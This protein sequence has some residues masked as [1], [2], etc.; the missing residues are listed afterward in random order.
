M[1]K[2]AL[3]FAWIVMIALVVCIPFGAAYAD[4]G[5][6]PTPTFPPP[7]TATFTVPPPPT[8]TPTLPYPPPPLA[9][10]GG[11]AEPGVE[12]ITEIQPGSPDLAATALVQTLEPESA[13]TQEERAFPLWPVILVLGLGL[14]VV[15]GIVGYF[16][17]VRQ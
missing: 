4:A 7:P 13:T 2:P 12:T 14:V 6:P 10:E 1:S 5:G 11:A 17:F 15:A 8:A 16:I 3:H 9:S